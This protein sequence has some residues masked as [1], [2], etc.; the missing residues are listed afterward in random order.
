MGAFSLSWSKNYHRSN[1]VQGRVESFSWTERTTSI[2]VENGMLIESIMIGGNRHGR[3]GRVLWKSPVEYKQTHI[4][5]LVT[6]LWLAIKAL[7]VEIPDP[8]DN[9]HGALDLLG[10]PKTLIDLAFLVVIV[11]HYM[12]TTAKAGQKVMKL[13]FRPWKQSSE[14]LDSQS[15]NDPQTAQLKFQNVGLSKIVGVIWM[16][17]IMPA[18]QTIQINGNLAQIKDG[19]DENNP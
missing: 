3:S 7:V 15:R 19:A 16:P 4:P 12:T 18:N 6:L 8:G 5:G 13:A 11:G 17:V 1:C 2:F 10:I 9:F 14:H